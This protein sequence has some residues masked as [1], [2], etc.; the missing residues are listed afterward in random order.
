MGDLHDLAIPASASMISKA[1]IL[2]DTVNIRIPLYRRPR[3]RDL[4]S[5]GKKERAFCFAHEYFV[6]VSDDHH[7]S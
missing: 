1:L 6:I 2:I 5:V 3:R 7:E 4:F